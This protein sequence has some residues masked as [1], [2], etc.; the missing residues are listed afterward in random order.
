MTTFTKTAET[1]LPKSWTLALGSVILLFFINSQ[2]ISMQIVI[3]P[4]DKVV[5]LQ[6]DGSWH[7]YKSE[8][9][10]TSIEKWQTLMTPPDIIEFFKG[11]FDKVGVHIIDTGEEFTCIH[12]GNQIEFENKLE[13]GKVDYIVEIY[14]YQVDRL[15]NYVSTGELDDIE[16]FRIARA[17]MN[18]KVAGAKSP[19]KNPLM[20]NFMFRWYIKGNNLVHMTIISPNPQIEKDAYLTFVY[21]DEWVGISGL[22]GS[23]KRIF[24]LTVDDALELQRHLHEGMKTDSWFHWFKTARWYKE[25][26]KKVSVQ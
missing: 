3:T 22:H 10:R 21:T 26:R 2:A 6:E 15:A 8:D 18:S 7:Y 23:P 25:W 17:F 13:R 20:R 5:I 12:K 11:I 24:N 14:S 9:E 19:L 1:H 4:D 16:K